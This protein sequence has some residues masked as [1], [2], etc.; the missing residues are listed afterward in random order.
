MHIDTV[1]GVDNHFGV[2]M[3]SDDID[4]FGTYPLKLLHIPEVGDVKVSLETVQHTIHVYIESI[5]R[6][7]VRVYKLLPHIFIMYCRRLI[8]FF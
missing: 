7:E 2:E 1:V 3:W 6:A 4:I 8:T 5:E